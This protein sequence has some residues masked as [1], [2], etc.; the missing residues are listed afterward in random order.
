MGYRHHGYAKENHQ[1]QERRGN[2]QGSTS[3]KRVLQQKGIEYYEIFSPVVRDTHLLELTRW[4][5]HLKQLDVKVVSFIV[6]WRSRFTWSSH[7][8][9]FNL[10][11][12]SWFAVWG[13]HSMVWNNLHDNDINGLI[14]KWF[15]FAT[16]DVSIIVKFT[17]KALMMVILFF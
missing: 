13:A 11:K 16:D 14:P 1:Y 12:S 7:K 9:L 15:K 5:M 4:D 2:V 17:L 10:D 8:V 3:S 6:I